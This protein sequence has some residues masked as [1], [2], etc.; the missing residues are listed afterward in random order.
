MIDARRIARVIPHRHPLLLLDR[1]S[2]LIPRQRLT[3]HRTVTGTELPLTGSEPGMC[4]ALL[5]ESWAQAA[6]VLL[7][8]EQPN[9]DVLDGQVA[10][11]GAVDG[12]RFGRRVR[13]GDEITHS[14]AFV[15]SYG[16]MTIVRGSARVDGDVVLEVGRLVA[17]LRPATSL[18]PAPSVLTEEKRPGGLWDPPLPMYSSVISTGSGTHSP[19]S[20]RYRN[21]DATN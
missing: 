20:I 12:I 8:W 14:V 16:D 11:V 15:R 2:E 6:L 7:L 1:V 21:E 3:G 18:R 5:V 13:T 9:P 17:A 4:A 19:K 10:V